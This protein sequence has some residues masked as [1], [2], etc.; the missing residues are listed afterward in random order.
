MTRTVAGH[1][2]VRPTEPLRAE[3]REL[4]PHIE[5]LRTAADHVG[6]VP[7]VTLRTEVDVAYAFLTEH[8]I[9]HA[10][11]EDEV[12]Y[13]EVGRALG[14]LGATATMSRDHVAVVELIDE[15]GVLRHAPDEHASELRR[16][17]YGL[18]ALVMTHFGKE[19]AIYL[20]LLDE[21]LSSDEASRMFASME[22][23]ASRARSQHRR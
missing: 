13:P 6:T 11:A 9:P 8:L 22:Q 15:L 12:L 7:A 14:A 16:V 3:H 21:H 19:E 18:H 4:L 10:M 2:S 5:A 23:A 17:L 1:P 20:P